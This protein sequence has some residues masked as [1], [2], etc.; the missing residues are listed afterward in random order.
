MAYWVIEERGD[1]EGGDPLT[2]PRVV[3]QIDSEELSINN[4][5]C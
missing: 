5:R 3:N 2:I 1:T 4:L